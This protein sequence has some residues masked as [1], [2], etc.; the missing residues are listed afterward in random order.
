MFFAFKV[1]FSCDHV[2]AAPPFAPEKLASVTESHPACRR[3]EQARRTPVPVFSF[4][5]ARP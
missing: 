1:V 4:K 3:H 5:V 2:P